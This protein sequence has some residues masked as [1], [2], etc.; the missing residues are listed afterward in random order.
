M[1]KSAN[2]G[3]KLV[4]RLFKICDFNPHCRVTSKKYG[5]GVT[6]FVSRSILKYRN[7]NYN[8]S[9]L[10]GSFGKF[11]APNMAS[12]KKEVTTATGTHNKRK[13]T[14]TFPKAPVSLLL[15]QEISLAVFNDWEL[16]LFSCFSKNFPKIASEVKK[17]VKQFYCISVS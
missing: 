14:S 17:I 10:F 11:S 3:I 4:T 7:W 12:T 16:A 5:I 2:A 6:S 13:L 1:F 9:L 8:A 15:Q